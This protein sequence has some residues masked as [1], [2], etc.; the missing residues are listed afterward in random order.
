MR[1]TDFP[2]KV[3]EKREGTLWKG[4]IMRKDRQTVGKKK[5]GRE[6]LENFLK[7][8]KPRKKRKGGERRADSKAVDACQTPFIV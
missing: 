1:E 7:L 8:L 5:K 3:G 6:R 4:G 2:F